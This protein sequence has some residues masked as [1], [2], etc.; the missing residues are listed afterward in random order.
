MLPSAATEQR[1]QRLLTEAGD[2]SD[3]GQ[4]HRVQLAGRGRPHAPQPLHREWMEELELPIGLHDQEP[5]GLGDAARDLARNFVRATPTVIGKPTRSRTSVRSRSA[6]AAGEPASR[7][8]P[9]TSRKASSMDS[10][11]TSGEASSNTAN[12]AL[13]ASE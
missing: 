7:S 12:M 11:S 4:P 5:V 13:L 3:G 8:I 2:V 1:D 9:R 6:I 10:P